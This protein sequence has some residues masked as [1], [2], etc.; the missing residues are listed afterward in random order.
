MPSP[1]LLT[2]LILSAVVAPSGAAVALAA[3]VIPPARSFVQVVPS[4]SDCKQRFVAE[5][6]TVQDSPPDVSGSIVAVPPSYTLL[7]VKLRSSILVT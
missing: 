7:N 6:P 2:C 5:V 1:T 4:T 3:S